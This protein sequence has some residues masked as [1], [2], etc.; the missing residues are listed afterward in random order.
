MTKLMPLLVG[1]VIALAPSASNLV[2]AAPMSTTTTLKAHLKGSKEVGTAGAP[3]GTGLATI[4]ITVKKAGKPVN[5]KLCY[6]LTVSGFKLPA[7]GAHIHVG[8]AG[9]TGPIVL[10][11]PTAPGKNGKASGCT[12]AKTSLLK[13]I[14]KYPAGYYVNVHTT[15]YPDG[16]VRSQLGM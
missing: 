6:K 9:G 12:T 14:A 15:V 3:H 5:S 13:A 16:A 7:V 8:K 4:T 1:V 10:P 11:F 2:V